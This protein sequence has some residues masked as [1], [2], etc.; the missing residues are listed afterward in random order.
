MVWLV[1]FVINIKDNLCGYYY[2][3]HY[4]KICL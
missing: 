2:C 1:G 4:C 3:Y